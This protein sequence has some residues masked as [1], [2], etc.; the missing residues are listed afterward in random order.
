MPFEEFYRNLENVILEHNRIKKTKITKKTKKLVKNLPKQ[1]DAETEK[2]QHTPQS[3]TQE[4]KPKS[5]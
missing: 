4:P 3:E 5:E 1:P 2:I